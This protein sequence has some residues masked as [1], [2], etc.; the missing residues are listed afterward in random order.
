[1]NKEHYDKLMEGVEEWNRWRKEKPDI[2]P[3]LQE[4]YLQEA[5]LTSITLCKAKLDNAKFKGRDVGHPEFTTVVLE[6]KEA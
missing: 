1:M 3:D 4:A 5:D 2:F 6:W